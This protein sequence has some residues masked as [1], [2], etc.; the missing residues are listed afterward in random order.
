MKENLLTKFQLHILKTAVLWRLE[1]PKRPLFMIFTRIS[2]ISWFSIFVRP[3]TLKSAPGSFLRSWRKSD[4][5][6]LSHHQN[7]K[8]WIRPF[9]TSWPQMTLTWHKVTKGIRGYLK[10][11]Q[12]RSM[13]FHRI[14]FNVIRLL[15]PVRRT[16]TYIQTWQLTPPGTCDVISDVNTK[17]CKTFRKF[18][19]RAIKYR[20][21]IENWSIGLGNRREGGGAKRLPHQRTRSGNTHWGAG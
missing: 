7:S 4:S 14:C 19:I 12:I 13:S 16:M 11:S 21:R 6:H 9:L 10:A 1:C 15:C 20:F 8:F 3:R 18:M 17:F 2:A 5:N